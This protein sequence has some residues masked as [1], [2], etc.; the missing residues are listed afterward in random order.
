[1]K[2]T[3]VT[4]TPVKTRMT[5][6][7]QQR[8]PRKLSE[9]RNVPATSINFMNTK[10]IEK[11]NSKMTENKTER[12]LMMDRL[13]SETLLG[14]IRA[15][16]RR[17]ER[18]VKPVI[19][20][21]AGDGLRLMNAEQSVLNDWT[22]RQI[23][24]ALQ[25][26]EASGEVLVSLG[27]KQSAASNVS[28]RVSPLEPVARQSE[29]TELSKDETIRLIKTDDEFCVNVVNESWFQFIQVQGYPEVILPDTDLF[30]LMAQDL[31]YQQGLTD[32][33]LAI[34]RMP[35]ENGV[36]RLARYKQQFDQRMVE[37]RRKSLLLEIEL[38]QQRER[39]PVNFIV[40]GDML[41]LL[42][43]DG[44]PSEPAGSAEALDALEASGQ[45]YARRN[46]YRVTATGADLMAEYSSMDEIFRDDQ[47]AESLSDVVE[48]AQSAGFQNLEIVKVRRPA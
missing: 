19:F 5:E 40:I 28:V 16:Y 18:P 46:G 3:T 17:D 23:G 15:I 8:P 34:C 37:L 31:V 24:E 6:S 33:Q 21:F 29:P 13:R 43:D 41:W 20:Q 11:E 12:P 9:R 47:E 7:T 1:M 42:G 27:Y 2:A 45:V 26:L 35:D 22:P 39:G 44:L 4:N 10:A 14:V 25:A 38:H 30:D 32:R 48:A 36:P